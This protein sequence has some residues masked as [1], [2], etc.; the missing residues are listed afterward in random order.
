MRALGRHVLA[1]FYGYAAAVFLIL[2]WNINQLPVVRGARRRLMLE[3]LMKNIALQAGDCGL[4]FIE[5]HSAINHTLRHEMPFVH[6]YKAFVP[7]QGY[8]AKN[9]K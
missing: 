9:R 8:Q 4:P 7:S 6:S 2:N 1:E 3:C 5:V